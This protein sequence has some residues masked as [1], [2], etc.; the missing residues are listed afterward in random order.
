M[1]DENR[2]IFD[3]LFFCLPD[4]HGVAGRCRLKAD[5][6][7][8]DLL[9]GVRAGDF[10]A[11]DRRIN[12]AHIGAARF[13]NE[14]ITGGTRHAQ[15]VTE[16]TEN[17]IGATRNGV[18]L[19]DHFE[20][21]DAHRASWPVHKLNLGRQEMVDTVFDDGVCLASA[22]FHQDPRP[23]DGPADFTDDF[24]SQRLATILVEV[25]HRFLAPCPQPP[26]RSI[27]PFLPVACTFAQPLLR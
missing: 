2:K 18:G 13:E 12:H 3:S 22:N 27:D 26:T 16:R 1:R 7:K 10:K 17:H 15:H 14:K 24:L 25:L 8:D 9:V 5:C 23:S 6:E 4:R 21:G 20:R 11:I 19:V